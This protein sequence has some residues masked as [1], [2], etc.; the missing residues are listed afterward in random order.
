MILN[1]ARS[2]CLRIPTC[3]MTFSTLRTPLFTYFH[4]N[5]TKIPISLTIYTES[6][7]KMPLHVYFCL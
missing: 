7:K 2:S 1:H 3:A 5:I 6:G 4:L